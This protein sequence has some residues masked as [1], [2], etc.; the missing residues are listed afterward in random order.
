MNVRKHP[1]LLAHGGVL[2]IGSVMVVAVGIGHTWSDA[3][4]SEIFVV[5]IALFDFF[6]AGT[7]GDVG[8]IYRRRTDERQREVIMKSS[9]L[10]MLVMFALCYGV[11]FILIA[12]NKNYWQE[13]VIGSAGGVAFFV[14]MT[15]FGVHDEVAD[16]SSRGIMSTEEVKPPM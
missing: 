14:G 12:L 8:A 9:R 6:L 4:I 2:A 3:L 13:D 16:S 15:I 11:A 7:K 1:R 10:A 5:V